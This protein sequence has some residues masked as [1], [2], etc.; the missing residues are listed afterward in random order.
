MERVRPALARFRCVAR[1][2]GVV[3]AAVVGVKSLAPLR[4]LMP[5]VSWSAPRSPAVKTNL[6]AD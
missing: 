2:D 5:I 1:G 3:S 4:G 6:S